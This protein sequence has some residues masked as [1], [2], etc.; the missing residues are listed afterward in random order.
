MSMT[1]TLKRRLPEPLLGAIRQARARSRQLV[2]WSGRELNHTLTCGVRVAI[3]NASDWAVYNEVFVD[4]EYDRAIHS[5]IASSV[6]RPLIVDLGANVGYFALRFADLWCRARPDEPFELIS[7]EGAAHTYA[8]L[9]HHLEQPAIADRCVARHGLVGRRTGSAWISTSAQSGMNSIHT[10]QSFSRTEVPFIDLER[11]V[12]DRTI[13]LLKCDIEGAE[14]MFC[15]SYPDLLRRVAT[16]V[17]ELHPYINDENRCRDLLRD[18][19][20]VHHRVVRRY[21]GGSVEI[22]S[23][24]QCDPDA[25]T[26][27]T[28]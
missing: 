17:I 13:S 2:G 7:V 8:Q 19:G 10:R 23:R 18:A 3:T 9:R 26:R 4:G 22:F 20:L 5:V 21:E 11:L 25:G 27:G 15:E 14:E 12:P 6:P 28:E 1:V 16:L 24:H